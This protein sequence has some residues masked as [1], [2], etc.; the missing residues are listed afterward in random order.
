MLVLCRAI[1]HSLCALPFAW[2]V[3]ELAV[4]EANQLGADPVKE[5]I[6]FLGFSAVSILLSLFV[7]GILFFVLK[8][9]HLQILRRPLGIWAWFYVLLHIMAYLLLELGLDLSLF[10]RELSLRGYLLLGLVA[11]GILTLMALSSLP[12]A[13]QIMGRYWHYLHKFGYLALLLAAVH[14]YWAVK[15]LNLSVVLY[16]FFSVLIVVWELAR[17]VMRAKRAVN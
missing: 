3:W 4:G 16:L 11:F 10:L 2:L 7:L 17:L 14:Y 9:P 1:I 6:H 8:R 15:S 13:K 12:K 5:M